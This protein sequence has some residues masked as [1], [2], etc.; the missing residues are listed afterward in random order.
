MRKTARD[1]A[2][3]HEEAGEEVLENPEIPEIDEIENFIKAEVDH[4]LDPGKILLSIRQRNHPPGPDIAK[5]TADVE[6]N[7]QENGEAAQE[8]DFEDPG[9]I[10][11]RTPQAGER[12]RLS[13][14]HNAVILIFLPYQRKK[15]KQGNERVYQ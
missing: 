12:S 9:I 10:F 3:E 11:P 4:R 5:G 2:Q 13:L 6:R 1:T 8:V 15:G 14:F 7:H